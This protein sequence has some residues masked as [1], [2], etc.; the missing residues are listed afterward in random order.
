M[1]R[2][3]PS[4]T[5]NYVANTLKTSVQMIMIDKREYARP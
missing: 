3:E 5:G 4:M 2:A 1:N